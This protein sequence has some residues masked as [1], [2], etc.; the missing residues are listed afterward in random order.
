MIHLGFGFI[1]GIAL[2]FR[3]NIRNIHLFYPTM[4]YVAVCKFLYEVIANERF[5]LW[6]IKPDFIFDDL[7][8]ILFHALFL[9]PFS[10]FLFLHN[11]P[12]GIKKQLFHYAWWIAIYAVLEWIALRYGNITYY[13]GW[14]FRWSVFFL[15]NMFVLIRIHD[16]HPYWGIILTVIS[17]LFYMTVFKMF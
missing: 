16:R 6:K 7:G 11:Y 8:L 5:Y 1:L 15:V 4:V 14:S 13:H 12:Q 2:Y 9:Y 17:T 3:S 10:A